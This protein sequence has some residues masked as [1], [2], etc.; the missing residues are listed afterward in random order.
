MCTSLTKSF[1]CCIIIVEIGQVHLAISLDNFFGCYKR[2]DFMKKKN[3]NGFTLIELIVVIAIVGI[4]SAILIPSIIRYT[5]KAAAKADIA[6]ARQIYNS[7]K[8]LLTEDPDAYTSFYKY[9]TTKFD[10]ITTSESGSESYRLV[11]VCRRNAAE[12]AKD[13]VKDAQGWRGGNNEAKYFR[14]ALNENLGYIEAEK[15]R[16]MKLTSHKDKG[17]TNEWLICYRENDPE[18]I[19]IWSGNV[20]GKWECGPAYRVYPS[21]EKEYTSPTR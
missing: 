8:T 1:K 19:E 15:A 20:K 18:H 6:N 14:E 17:E 16:S 10:V 7:V 3:Q 5:R 9:N 4:V 21:P 11:V 12:G 2:D 13:K